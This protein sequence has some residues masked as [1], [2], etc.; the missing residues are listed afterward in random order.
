MVDAINNKKDW[1]CDNTTVRIFPGEIRV[2]LHKN[3]I[4][5]INNDSVVVDSCG[6]HTSTTKSRLNAILSMFHLS[7][8]VQKNYTW[9]VNGKEFY[10][11]MTISY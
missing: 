11:G 4:A 6:W 1:N 3:R 9:H 8:I 5:T 7:G 10:D 2:Y